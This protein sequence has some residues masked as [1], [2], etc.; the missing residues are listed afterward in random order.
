MQ[1]RVPVPAPVS[2][3]IPCY[4]CS[5]TIKRAVSSV[6]EQTLLP[7]ETFL[8]D[9][10]SYD[11]GKTVALLH[12]LRSQYKGKTTIQV[13][14]LKENRGP[15]VARNTGWEAASQPFLAFL[16]ADDAWHPRKL[17]IQYKW[18][19]AHPE[20]ALAGHSSLWVREGKP[21]SPLPNE[22]SAWAVT[23]RQLLL[24]NRFQTRCV[25]IRREI[26]YRFDPT[27]RY[28]E[29]Y[30]LWLRI[31]LAGYPAWR[32]G[33]PLAFTYKADFGS[34]G[35][36]GHLWQMEKGELETYWQIY[37]GKRISSITMIGLVLLSLG[38]YLRRSLFTSVSKRS[39]RG[40]P[41]HG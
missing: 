13:I 25:M 41:H 21:P 2:V 11:D 27:K 22:W 17:E 29:D 30:L 14:Q 39:R 37:R 10:G 36:T 23:A 9:D 7:V 24:S 34:T 5:E 28:S 32:L 1:E 35:L 33:L 12:E 4:C 8:I 26:P 31:V 38:K 3:I 6:M 16:D 18:M 40:D 15:S 20:V 19:Q